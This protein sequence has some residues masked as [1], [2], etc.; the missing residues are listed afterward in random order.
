MQQIA[1]PQPQVSSSLQVNSLQ[2]S[3]IACIGDLEVIHSQ[4]PKP[5]TATR[6]FPEDNLV[7]EVLPDGKLLWFSTAKENYDFDTGSPH[8]FI[9]SRTVEPGS[10][11]SMIF[12]YIKNG[13]LI[14]Q[15][16]I[17]PATWHRCG[18]LRSRHSES[19]SIS[20][21]Y[22][23]SSQIL[24]LLDLSVR[25][26][27]VL[28][29]HC[30]SVNAAFASRSGNPEL[31]SGDSILQ[32]MGLDT[33]KMMEGVSSI[34]G[35]EG[36]LDWRL[37]FDIDS[38][39]WFYIYSACAFGSGSKEDGR[40]NMISHQRIGLPRLQGLPGPPQFWLLVDCSTPKE[41]KR[42]KKYCPCEARTHDGG[43]VSPKGASTISAE[44]K[45]GEARQISAKLTQQMSL[46]GRDVE[47]QRAAHP[48]NKSQLGEAKAGPRRYPHAWGSGLQC[49]LPKREGLYQVCAPAVKWAGSSAVNLRSILWTVEPRAVVY[50]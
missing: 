34:D 23:D 2:I 50:T 24:G 32:T 4:T 33:E 8:A 26:C 45:R 12:V 6:S 37:A 10:N 46:A 28:T 39:S 17:P 29:V 7:A 49:L 36:G 31:L 5:W 13:I 1:Q 47:N 22:L 21:K 11:D 40:L 15:L 48:S 38:H 41:R 14:G 16:T 3:G 44:P 30:V 18:F 42:E 25:T 19:R 27:Q 35:D 20:L 43:A 9:G